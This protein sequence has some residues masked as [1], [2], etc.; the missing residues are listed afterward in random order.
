MKF[1]IELIR[2]LLRLGPADSAQANLEKLKLLKQSNMD[3][4]EALKDQ[5]RDLVARIGQKKA[6]LDDAKI[7]ALRNTVEREIGELLNEVERL[8]TRE[9]YIVRNSTRISKLVEKHLQNQIAREQ[10]VS[11]DMLED[12]TLDT[13][14][15]LTNM[16]EE[17]R[18]MEQLESRKY[19]PLDSSEEEPTRE[20]E[21]SLEARLREV[22]IE[23]AAATPKKKPDLDIEE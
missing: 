12:V 22:G 23:D 19:R 1:L 16:E 7:P 2:K 11:E 15:V 4:L 17:D 20:A 3:S 8:N 13:E 9:D 6:E 21:A 5:I 10:G 14:E 18:A